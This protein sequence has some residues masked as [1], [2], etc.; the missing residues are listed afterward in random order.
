MESFFD[1]K[2]WSLEDT[3]SFY[4]DL[5][6]SALDTIPE[7]GSVMVLGPMFIIRK[8]EENFELFSRAQNFLLEKGE[9]VFNQLPFVDYN[10]GNAPFNYKIK[11]DIFYKGLINSG[12]IKACYLLPDWDKSEGTR[13]E[14]EYCKNAN[15]PVFEINEDF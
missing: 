3:R 15:V 8:P 7:N 2:I 10:I 6:K 1:K 11:F 14:I 5:L 13:T 9:S 4:N 12:K